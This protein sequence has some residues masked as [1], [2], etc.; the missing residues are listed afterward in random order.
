M[1]SLRR[2]SA[3]LLTLAIP[4]ATWAQA[5]EP[6]ALWH[7]AIGEQYQMLHQ[8]STELAN[9]LE[10]GCEDKA[11]LRQE[12]LAANRAWQRVRYVD[13]GPIEQQSRAWQL[14]FWPDRK[15]L[16]AKKVSAWLKA[17]N[18]PTAEQIKADSVALQGFPAMEYLLVEEDIASPQAC[19]LFGAIAEHLTAT[20]QALSDDWQA[21]EDHYLNTEGY[22]DT[23]VKSAMHGLEI[24]EEKRIAEPMGLRGKPRNGYLADAWR[25]GESVALIE[26]S[27][28][29]LE[30]SFLPGAKALLERED[31][32]ELAQELEA[33]LTATR[34]LAASLKPGLAP[35]LKNDEDYRQLQSLYL[36]VGK[37]RRLVNQEVA[38]ALDI[39]QGFNSSDGD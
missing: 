8:A 22:T 34:E 20:T 31:E 32:V 39:K 29:G 2:L 24:L 26:A 12:W 3:L 11:T 14:Q 30:Q 1:T 19:A 15:N 9:N 5:D 38:K 21:F 13:F 18:P 33:E 16:V 7:G 23:T 10:N 27:L 17:P 4:T 37:L 36:Q 28:A 35:A 6:K 25:S